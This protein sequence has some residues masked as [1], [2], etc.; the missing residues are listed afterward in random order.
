MDFTLDPNKA[1]AADKVASNIS[2]TGYYT[3]HFT[4]AYLRHTDNGAV[5]VGFSFK[6]D[7]ELTSNFEICT[8][9][10]DG[11]PTF[12]L[13]MLHAGLSCLKVRS[14]KAVAGVRKA[15][16]NGAEQDI[17]C[18]V[19]PDFINKPIGLILQKV[20][21]EKQD[22]SGVGYR[23]ELKHFIDP[24]TKQTGGEVLNKDAAEKFEK[25]LGRYT[26]KL[27]ATTAPQKPKNSSGHDF[28]V[29]DEIPF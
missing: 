3:G 7:E 10:R 13:D 14:A 4:N 23:M 9:G 2:A 12:G 21:Y 17:Q 20:E 16:I 27:I 22:G 6:S 18:E 28:I 26:D 29:E 5:M 8:H 24:L 19:Y 15:Y 1:K 25:L 11:K